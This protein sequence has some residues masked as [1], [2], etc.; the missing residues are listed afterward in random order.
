[1][2]QGVS[3][4]RTVT[5]VAGTK[6][7][8]EDLVAAVPIHARPAP[9]STSVGSIS[10]HRSI[11]ESGVTVHDVKGHDVEGH[12]VEGGFNAAASVGLARRYLPQLNHSNAGR[13]Y[14]AQVLEGIPVARISRMN[15]GI[16]TDQD[17]M[18]VASSPQ[19]IQPQFDTLVEH[20]MGPL[21]EVLLGT[22]PR[23]LEPKE[24]G[25]GKQSDPVKFSLKKQ[26]KG[27]TL[28]EACAAYQLASGRLSR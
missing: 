13:Q 18:P 12:D 17:S 26:Q 23:R 25:K 8:G 21:D 24:K 28:K 20:Q 11:P 10:R 14:Q 3:L 22:V 19:I 2:A 16:R 27:A 6:I 4:V 1:M 9:G 7:N 5:G 15:Q